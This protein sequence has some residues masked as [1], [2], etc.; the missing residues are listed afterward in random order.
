MIHDALRCL[1]SVD[2][3]MKA[4]AAI[5]AVE[6]FGRSA[7]AAVRQ[8]LDGTR[9]TLRTCRVNGISADDTFRKLPIPVIGRVDDRALVF[10][11]RCLDDEP[12]FAANLAGLK[13]YL[14]ALA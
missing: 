10:G 4:Q 13:E 3:M 9:A 5:T 8:A 2:D 12:A 14:D 1:P 7:V 6:Q 11:L